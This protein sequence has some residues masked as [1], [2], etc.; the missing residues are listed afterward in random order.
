[1]CVFFLLTVTMSWLHR[2]PVL[3]LSE[4]LQSNSFFLDLWGFLIYFLSHFRLQ[5]SKIATGTIYFKINGS[6]HY[7]SSFDY[8]ARYVGIGYGIGLN[9][10]AFSTKPINSAR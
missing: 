9:D 4:H 5:S 3:C 7:F 8:S 6:C 2:S 10:L 1:M